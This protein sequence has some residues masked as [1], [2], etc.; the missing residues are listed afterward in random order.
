MSKF[1][2]SKE[3]VSGENVGSKFQAG[4]VF[5][6]GRDRRRLIGTEWGHQVLMRWNHAGTAINT[7]STKRK[8]ASNYPRIEI[9]A[10]YYFDENVDPWV[11]SVQKFYGDDTMMDAFK[12]LQ[13]HV[14]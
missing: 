7:Y 1:Y 9:L 2:E 6:L 10:I 13:E 5:N 14:Y 11:K 4:V 3:L 8:F 12:W